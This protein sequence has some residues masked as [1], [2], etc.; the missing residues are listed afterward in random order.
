MEDP[1]WGGFS[2]RQGFES[3]AINLSAGARLG[4][5]LVPAYLGLG[6]GKRCGAI[7]PG[8]P[9]RWVLRAQDS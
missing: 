4:M 9:P 3:C 6:V 8:P 1:R 5:K 2:H 7:V